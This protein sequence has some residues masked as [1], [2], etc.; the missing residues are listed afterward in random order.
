MTLLPMPYGACP[1]PAVPF[2][3]SPHHPSSSL[4]HFI[5]QISV[6]NLTECLKSSWS[7]RGFGCPHALSQQLDMLITEKRKFYHALCRNVPS[8]IM[9]KQNKS[10]L[11]KELSRASKTICV[12]QGKMSVQLGYGRCDGKRSPLAF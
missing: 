8:R 4:S 10:V 9:T 6:T 12:S 11:S 7:Y 3:S 2:S 5:L 1:S